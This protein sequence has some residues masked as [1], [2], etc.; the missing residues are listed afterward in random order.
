MICKCFCCGKEYNGP[1]Q[2][3]K[4]WPFCDDCMKKYNGKPPFVA[5]DGT[6]LHSRISYYNYLHSL[7]A[8]GIKTEGKPR[9]RKTYCPYCGA[10]IASGNT[11]GVN[12]TNGL[13]SSIIHLR[14]CVEWKKLVAKYGCHNRIPEERKLTHD[15]FFSIDGMLAF[16]HSKKKEDTFCKSLSY[17]Q[18]TVMQMIWIRGLFEDNHIPYEIDYCSI[19][20]KFVRNVV[21]ELR[22]LIVFDDEIP[23]DFIDSYR[24]QADWIILDVHW[25]DVIK[26]EDAEKKRILD[27]VYSR[28]SELG[29][30]KEN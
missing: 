8:K 29:L 7:E 24:K 26:D 22:M 10:E 23:K 9:G 28:Q 14:H 17:P 15:R 20:F 19:P 30:K 6:V 11:N 12:K 5:F 2:R 4:N 1:S 13:E 27:T 16:L 25:A 3:G 21:E 18:T